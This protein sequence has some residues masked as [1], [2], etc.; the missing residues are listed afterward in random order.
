MNVIPVNV[1]RVSQNLRAFNLLATV[2]GANVDLFRVQNQL[3]TGLRFL[4]P[5]ED[6]VRS[7]AAM[8]L[9]RHADTLEM[10]EANLISA[11]T[12]LRTGESSMQEAIDIL[13]EAHA[14]AL[15]ALSDTI[16]ADERRALAVVLDA[17][18]DQAVRIG[19]REHLGTYLFSGHFGDDDPFAMTN[20]GVLFRGDAGRM[21]AIVDT[22][23]SQEHFTISGQELFNAVSSG[24]RGF[25]DLNPQVT[26]N[27]R[28]SDLRGA[29]GAGVTLGRIVVSEGAQ[30]VEIDLS[31]ADTV[32]DVLDRLNAEMPTS[33][34]ATLTPTGINVIPAGSAPVTITIRD[35]S[36]GQTAKQLGIATGSPVGFVVGG[37]LD[38]AL[39]PRTALAD[40][41]LGAGI[42]LSSGITIRNG[43]LSDTIDF[44]GAATI[45]DVL[46]RINEANVGAWARIGEDGNTIDILSRV[47][48]SDLFV[49]EAGGLAATSLGVRS[50]YAE[51][52]LAALNDGAGVLTIE[53][54]DLRI[55]T[56]SGAMIDI[57][58]DDLNIDAST[59]LQDVID[60]FNARGGG[61][62]TASLTS[63][64]NGIEIQDNTAG[65]GVLQIERLNVSPAIDGLGLDVPASGTA[66][67]GADV[68]PVRVDGAFT[69]LLELRVGL[70]NDDTS[71][72][73]N[74]GQRLEQALEHM[75][76]VQGRLASQAKTMEDRAVRIDSE[77]TAT[78]VMAS[79]VRDVDFTEAIVRFQQV[80]T[81]LQAN[82]A[83]SARVMSL[84]LI[85][86]L[87]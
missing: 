70:V 9:E 10:I 21:Q 64:G 84:S 20:E 63:V 39:T 47:S 37:D 43:Q 57:D 3:A 11:N 28:L 49:E 7:S 23:F 62:I 27:T 45:E 79:D 80:Q 25:V 18:I 56:A 29:T 72:L 38:P 59:T 5:S 74:A 75:Q 54:D 50:L 16:S 46:S 30:Q 17:A 34:Q 60:L 6:P 78:Q 71:L 33:L 81:A 44:T 82:L 86:F 66:L 4:S 48:G 26:I 83:T 68:N 85:D 65:A 2:R 51:T 15:E 52:K 36:G 40:L 32:G 14:T 67:V 12:A 1:A 42:D 8:R 55:T 35:L 41:N 24:V 76:Q 22:D 61:D 58:L 53:G 69:A 73:S 19:N 31:E 87:R 77:K 13:R